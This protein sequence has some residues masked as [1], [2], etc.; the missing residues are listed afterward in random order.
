MLNKKSGLDHPLEQRTLT[1]QD[2]VE[3]VRYLVNLKVGKGEIDDIDHLGESCSCS[4][5]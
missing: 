4:V 2:I 1:A 3:V 5:G